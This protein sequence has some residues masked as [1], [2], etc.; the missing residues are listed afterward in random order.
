MKANDWDWIFFDKFS[1][2]LPWNC[3][4]CYYFWVGYAFFFNDLK[5]KWQITRAWRFK[6]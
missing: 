4:E 6:I 5:N 1:T 2:S 3:C